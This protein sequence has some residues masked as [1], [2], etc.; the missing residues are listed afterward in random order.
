[1]RHAEK[2]REASCP[3]ADAIALKVHLLPLLLLSSLLS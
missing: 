3:L 2:S 1:M